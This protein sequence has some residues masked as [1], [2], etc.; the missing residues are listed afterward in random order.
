[1][2]RMTLLARKEGMSTSD[3][4]SYWA[5]P[6]GE[7]ALE[8][9]GIAQYIQNRVEKVLWS[10]TGVPAFSVDGIVEL[11]FEG[12]DAMRRAQASSIGRLHIPADEPNFLR[13]WTLCIVDECETET[14]SSNVKVMVPFA[15]RTG[16]D[17]H[18]IDDR[19]RQ[20]VCELGSE[21]RGISTNWTASTARR[22]RLWAEPLPPTGFLTFWFAN[23]RAAH[24]AFSV[25]GPLAQSL[26]SLMDEG[27]AYLVDQLV[28]RHLKEA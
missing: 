10:R 14:D 13:G 27:T 23:L 6:H 28:L 20:L 11:W 24:D 8:M 19:L 5:G 26:Q 2:K 7:L 4:R 22:D 9:D 16:E 15:A 3:F 17:N 25:E 12:E 18:L 1:M 21:I